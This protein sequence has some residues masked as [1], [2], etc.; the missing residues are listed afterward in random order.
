M[1]TVD[2]QGGEM[3]DGGSLIDISINP[4]KFNLVFGTVPAP[5]RLFLVPG[6]IPG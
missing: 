3:W 2:P 1:E 6:G 5:A 4:K